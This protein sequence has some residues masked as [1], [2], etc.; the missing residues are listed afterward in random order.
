MTSILTA[1]WNTQRA[2]MLDR[3]LSP[4]AKHATSIILRAGRPAM[5]QSFVAH[6]SYFPA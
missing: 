6:I 3:Y 1:A 4:S 5:E 2:F